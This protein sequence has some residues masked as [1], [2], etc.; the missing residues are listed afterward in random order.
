MDVAGC[1]P[2][3][4]CSFESKD[5]V[6]VGPV[7]LINVFDDRFVVPFSERLT[8]YIVVTEPFRTGA[9]EGAD[10]TLTVVILVK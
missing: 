3:I 1:A 8:V 7:N 2:S 9:F 5:I 6:G 10:E 4:P